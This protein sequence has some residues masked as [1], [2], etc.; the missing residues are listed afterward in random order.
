M[1]GQ[2]RFKK[3]F[4]KNEAK[5]NYWMKEEQKVQIEGGKKRAR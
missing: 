5:G 3:H 4:S 2:C 1:F